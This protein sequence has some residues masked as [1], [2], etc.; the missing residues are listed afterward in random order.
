MR[1]AVFLSTAVVALTAVHAGCAPASKITGEIRENVYHNKYVG[2]RFPLPQGWSLAA[3]AQV[4]QLFRE[5]GQE[6]VHVMGLDRPEVR[7]AVSR[8]PGYLLFAVSQRP[9]DSDVQELNSNLLLAAI[10]VRGH[11]DEVGSGADYLRLVRAGLRES[12]SVTTISDITP[13]RLG[14]EE[15]HRLDA[16]LAVGGITAYQRQL[17]YI[18]NDYLVIV[19]VTAGSAAGRDELTRVAD[20]L[21]FSPVTAAVDGSTEGRAFRRQAGIPR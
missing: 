10:S 15:F 6:V 11:R 17:A 1:G 2:L 12:Q 9:F 16:C 5:G 21:R 19:N 20:A 18:A 14:G 13:Q 4:T 8:M 7:R 3:D